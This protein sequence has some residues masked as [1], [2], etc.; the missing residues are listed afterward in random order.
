MFIVSSISQMEE[1][2]RSGVCEIMVLGRLAASLLNQ[3]SV[4]EQ[5]GEGQP[6]KIKINGREYEFTACDLRQPHAVLLA[7]IHNERA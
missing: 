2:L 3:Y 5:S 7:A 4:S 6:Q 1:A